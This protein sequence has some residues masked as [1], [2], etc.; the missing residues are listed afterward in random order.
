MKEQLTIKAN[1][2]ITE[3][4]VETGEVREWSQ[5]NMIVDAGLVRNN[6]WCRNTGSTAASGIKKFGLGTSDTAVTAAD[7][8]LA[9]SSLWHAINSMTNH[10]DSMGC[11][12]N[13][14][15]AVGEGNGVTYKEAG[16]FYDVPY[17][18]LARVVL[19]PTVVK[20]I[21]KKFDF[22]WSID[23]ARG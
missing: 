16:L 11:S 5:E 12:Y 6:D 21:T 20:I 17:T 8:D 23:Y 15:L 13:T 14:T 1:L 10:G 4:N 9:A 19:V 7:T 22:V 2:K 18:M 3:T